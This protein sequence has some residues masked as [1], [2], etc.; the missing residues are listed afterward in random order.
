MDQI[1]A[2]LAIVLPRSPFD[3]KGVVCAQ[4]GEAIE[5]SQILERLNLKVSHANLQVP[6][7]RFPLIDE[8]IEGSVL[9]DARLHSITQIKNNKTTVCAQMLEFKTYGASDGSLERIIA[10]NELYNKLKKWER[11][12]SHEMFE[13]GRCVVM[14]RDDIELKGGARKKGAYCQIAWFF[15]FVPHSEVFKYKKHQPQQAQ[16]QAQPQDQPQDQSESGNV[17][18]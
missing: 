6:D 18:L 2:R 4:S 1:H 11:V 3:F 14:T 12:L 10:A 17:Q 7:I 9:E 13:L 8:L 5:E 15:D 16:P